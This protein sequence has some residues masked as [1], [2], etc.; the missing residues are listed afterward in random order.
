[1][2]PERHSFRFFDKRL[3]VYRILKRL[4]TTL[5]IILMI[6]YFFCDTVVLRTEQMKPTLFNGDRVILLKTPFIKPWVTLFRRHIND[7]VIFD[8]PHRLNKTVCFRVTGLPG[9]SIYVNNGMFSRSNKPAPRI[10]G[11]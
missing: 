8:L 4:L 1:M 10:T 5:L 2:V 3:F 11:N 6:K 9:D 7:C